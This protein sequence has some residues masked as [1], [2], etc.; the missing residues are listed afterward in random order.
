MRKQHAYPRRVRLLLLLSFIVFAGARVVAAEDGLKLVEAPQVPIDSATRTGS[1]LLQI[2]NDG[3]ADASLSLVVKELRSKITGQL[4]RTKVAFSLQ[5]EVAGKPVFPQTLK[6]GDVLVLKVDVSN[7]TEPGESTADIFQGDK[8]LGVLTAV[9]DRPPFGVKPS[10]GLPD[11]PELTLERGVKW[12]LIVKNDDAVTYPVSWRLLVKGVTLEGKSPVFLAPNDL[13]PIE[14]DPPGTWFEHWMDGFFKPEDQDGVLTLSLTPG[15]AREVPGENQQVPAIYA[16]PAAGNDRSWPSKSIATKIHLNYWSAAVKQVVGNI[17][18]L[19]VLVA[20]GIASLLVNAYLPNRLRSADAEEKLGALGRRTGGISTMV[21]S[22]LRVLIRVER[23]RLRT[24][25]KSRGYFSPDFS[26][27]FSQLNAGITALTSRIEA[28]EQLDTERHRFDSLRVK[29]PPTSLSSLNDSLQ[30][31]AD[32]LR[33]GRPT[34]AEIDLAKTRIA[35]ASEQISKAADRV[36]REEQDDEFAKQIMNRL[37]HLKDSLKNYEST[38]IYKAFHD[39]TPGPFFRLTKTHAH[40]AEI[41]P[42]DYAAIDTDLVKLAVILDYIRLHQARSEDLQKKLEANGGAQEEIMKLLVPMSW[43]C[44]RSAQL[45]VRQVQCGIFEKD[46]RDVLPHGVSIDTDRQVVRADEPVEF[47]VRFHH[48]VFD[49]TAAR[50]AWS[51]SWNFGDGL[52]ERGWSA[53]HY[54]P[55]TTT[56]RWRR[57]WAATRSVFDRQYRKE[58]HKRNKSGPKDVFVCFQ[59]R[60]GQPINEKDVQL[61]NKEDGQPINNK[62]KAEPIKISRPV[63][64]K[65]QDSDFL[66]QRTKVEMARLA[67]G[68]LVAIVALAAGA[69]EQLLKLD[70]L[71][72]LLA[73]FVIGFA[74]DTIKNLVTQA[75]AKP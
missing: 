7:V 14:I 40:P 45:L 29:L 1:T 51:Y 35:K 13:T 32:L 47:S 37:K 42:R 64:V 33:K 71:P 62:D 49:R 65:P 15:A 53:W 2:K 59:D 67:I 57:F 22:R 18:I 56:T 10:G 41:S 31:A 23:L 36:N 54:Y 66:G 39:H 6:P 74:A 21:D 24:L 72:G 8:S 5:P 16:A 20:G 52:E 43:E 27:A 19:L 69:K 11:K 46:L 38:L 25:L 4:L 68:L 50:E 73:V 55:L 44:I 28:A 58:W 3:K 12:A 63:E 34:Q 75:P 30:E 17:I 9:N 26:D 70:V 60:D 61:I 48:P